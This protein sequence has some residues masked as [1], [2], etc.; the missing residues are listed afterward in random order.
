MRQAPASYCAVRPRAGFSLIEL[1][2]AISIIALLISILLPS[3]SS[4]RESM[5]LSQ[6]AS[7]IRQLGIGHA[8]YANDND[9]M[10]APSSYG[11][12][13]PYNFSGTGTQWIKGGFSNPGGFEG[14][15][16]GIGLLYTEGYLYGGEAMYDPANNNVVQYDSPTVGWRKGEP[17]NNGGNRWMNTNYLQRSCIGA[18]NNNIVNNRNDKSLGTG[19]QVFTDIDPGGAAFLTCRNDFGFSPD[20]QQSTVDWTH[21]TGYNV[22]YLDGAVEYV[23]I[24]GYAGQTA[25]PN[26]LGSQDL[27]IANY[28]K[29]N[30]I[31]SYKYKP[32]VLEKMFYYKL[33]KQNPSDAPGP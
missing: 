2:V 14:T 32:K 28:I 11:A 30:G 27:S 23:P 26:T 33:D 9:F 16:I 10:V 31:T 7:N 18:P 8:A 29:A 21:K 15:W 17:W 22:F 20:G 4:V 25:D 5:K 19:R 13:S 24:Q 1:L 6:C 3:L 12:Y